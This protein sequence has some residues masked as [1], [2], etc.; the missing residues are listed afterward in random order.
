MPVHPEIK[1]VKLPFY[2]VMSEL[3][4]PAS[5]LAQGGNRFHE[6]RFDFYLTPSQ[7]TDIASNRDVT[8]G[9]RTDFL[10]QIQLRF[11]PLVTATETGKVIP[12]LMKIFKKSTSFSPNVFVCEVIVYV[13]LAGSRGLRR[14]STK[15]KR[16]C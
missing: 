1:L 9:S 10:Y 7:A 13:L 5:L 8:P 11:C 15:P 6:T 2:D 3:L 14:V 16:P 12:K 4:K